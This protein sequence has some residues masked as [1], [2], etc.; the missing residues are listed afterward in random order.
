MRYL[1]DKNIFTRELKE[2]V[3]HRTDLCITEDL[4][5]E[6]GFTRQDIKK[7]K[8]SKIQIFKF[9][10]IHY[11][12]LKDILEQQGDNVN[13]LNL[14]LGEGT[15]DIMLIAYVLAERDADRSWFPEEYIIVTK[16]EELTKVA[17]SFGIICL[18]EIS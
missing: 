13:L 18:P 7:I 4:I 6:S 3:D 10:K 9:R 8:D 17:K 5:D 11:E 2:N 12:K 1:L 15:A 14:F 16:D